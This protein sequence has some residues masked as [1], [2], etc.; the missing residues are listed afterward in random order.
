MVAGAK[1]GSLLL[2]SRDFVRVEIELALRLDLPIIPVL[3]GGAKMPSE[4]DLPESLAD[5]AYR[6]GMELRPDPNFHKDMNRL[7]AGMDALLNGMT[8][9]GK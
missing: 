7:I 3:V 4:R 2:N 5:L 8:P 6:N 1:L 9:S